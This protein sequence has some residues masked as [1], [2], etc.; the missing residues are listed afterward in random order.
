MGV[1]KKITKSKKHKRKVHPAANRVRLAALIDLRLKMYFGLMTHRKIKKLPSNLLLKKFIHTAKKLMAT[2]FNFSWQDPRWFQILLLSTF[3]TYGIG[4]LDWEPD[5]W[6]LG[7]L[8][9]VS[10]ITQYVFS[11]IWNQPFNSIVS[12]CIS[13]LS[14]NLLLQTD[15]IMVTALAAFIAVVVKY[16]FKDQGKHFINPSM[17]GLIFCILI[18]R[19]AWISP[20]QWGSGPVILMMICSGGYMILHRVGRW[21]TGLVFL[22]LYAILEYSWQVLYLGWPMDVLMP[23]LSSGALAL[24]SSFMITDPVT[25]PSHP[26][27][28]ILFAILVALL[29]F[30]LGTFQYVNAAP[31]WALFFLTPLTPI[32]N[33]WKKGTPFQWL[34]NP[35]IQ[36][37]A[38]GMFL[39]F[40]FFSSTPSHAFCGFYVA[41]AG[42][43]LFNQKSEV[44]MVRDGNKNTITMSNDFKGNAKNFAMVVPVPVVLK[45]E[46]IQVVERNIFQFLDDYSAPRLVE[47]HDEHPCQI[48]D[49]KMYLKSSTARTT[50]ENISMEMAEGAVRKKV[51]IEA[52]YEVGEYNILILSAKE[53]GGLKEWLTENGYAIPP[54]G[55]EVLEPYI[56]N[57]LKFF[58]VK[59]N[60]SKVQMKDG[61]VPLRPLQITFEH[62]KFMLPIRLGMANAKGHQDLIVYAFSKQGRI[63]TVNY[64]TSKLPTGNLIPTFI[65]DKFGEFYKSLFE[66]HW[67]R[68]GRSSVMLEYAWNVTPS[69]SGMKCDPCMG[70]PPMI[71]E[72][73]QAGVKWNA[74]LPVYFTRMHIRY[75]REEFPQD[76]IFQETHDKTNFQARYVMNWA[77]KVDKDCPERKNYYQM[78]HQRR[79]KEAMELK[80]LTGWDVHQY[81]NYFQEYF[82][83]EEKVKEEIKPIEIKNRKNM[84]TAI[85]KSPNEEKIN[86]PINPEN[87]KPKRQRKMG[88]SE[89]V[90]INS[91]RYIFWLMAGITILFMIFQNP[92][93]I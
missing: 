86:T 25:T 61:Y 18:S 24:F 14:L 2:T 72:L 55:E 48:F 21:E 45:R 44:I 40:G 3:Y 46:D 16:I 51:T 64:R 34:P 79:Q 89:E 60:I 37:T 4:F 92:K 10:S 50:T 36:K 8:I 90:P 49:N 57:N 9:G 35:S 15:S 20:G 80:Y 7:T 26:R 88:V 42:T 11:R 5:L 53:S 62:D 83:E 84:D 69:F 52:S 32:L 30:Y 43:E 58:V 75:G 81:D 12:A 28:R 17:A 29:A 76:L 66:R 1:S 65:K 56:K 39:I 78:V 68:E 47:Y 6:K 27:S 33:R 82:I 70:P 31:I 22:T 23:K 87:S 63:E 13:G 19:E 77:Q 73:T 38:I 85:R 93:K 41:K 67:E 91:S 59:V 54:K 74:G 71:K